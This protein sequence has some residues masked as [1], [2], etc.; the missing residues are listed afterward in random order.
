[1]TLVSVG[2]IGRPHGLQGEVAI[3]GCTLSVPELHAVRRFTWRGRDRERTLTLAT[4]RPANTRVLAHFEGVDDV[5]AASALTNGE[6][7]A[8][9]AE[10]PDPG[11]GQAYA[12]QM[13]G[14]VVRTEEGRALGTLEAVIPTGAHPVYVVRGER[15]LLLPAIPDVVREVDLEQRTM[16]VRLPAG[17]EEL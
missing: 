6:L 10:L 12:F 14:L 13:V 16:T 2:R 15:E 11:P 8:D 1:M 17:I 5:E 7:L 3:N 4:A 9:T